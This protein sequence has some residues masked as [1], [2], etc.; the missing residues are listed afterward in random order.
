MDEAKQHPLKACKPA[1]HT[2]RAQVAA[3]QA[4]AWCRAVFAG[5]SAGNEGSLLPDNLRRSIRFAL[6]LLAYYIQ[7][8]KT[9][10]YRV[11]WILTLG[12]M[13]SFLQ[14]LVLHGVPM[15]IGPGFWGEVVF[16]ILY[17]ATFIMVQR[18]LLARFRAQVRIEAMDMNRMAGYFLGL[19]LFGFVWLFVLG[20]GM[21]VL[22]T[23]SFT[24][25]LKD[26]DSLRFILV[27]YFFLNTIIF[28]VGVAYRW[29]R[30][31]RSEKNA[32][33]MA[34][35]AYMNTQLQM[36]R[37]QLNPHFLFNNLNIIAAT[38]RSK[39]MLAYEFTRNMASFYR[40]VLESEQGGLILLREELKTAGYYLY[41]LG[42]RFEEK[43]SYDIE[44]PDNCQD[45]CLLPDFILQPIIENAVKHNV[46]SRNMPLKILI[47]LKGTGILEVRNTYQ[48]K[49]SSSES[50]GIGWF[51]V[52]NRYRHYLSDRLPVK[53]VE[54]GWYVVQVPLIETT[55]SYPSI[56]KT[57]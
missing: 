23:G 45:S 15:V 34:E 40:K 49:D 39:P 18:K 38:I 14:E 1:R 13:V 37:Q 42:V 8:M 35:K 25:R 3:H 24:F 29:S 7:K 48:P 50:L 26:F 54:D 46:A 16:A 47:R 36:L 22:V 4:A 31:Y 21:Q 11:V 51:N 55:E 32:K 57:Q 19:Q 6:L 44:V 43:L 17:L 9:M 12:V 10:V 53:F 27:Y 20:I 2:V 41:L 30:M 52:E 5:S 33:H 28:S 56:P